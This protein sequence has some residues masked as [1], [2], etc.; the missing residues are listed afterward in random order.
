MM[1][2]IFPL[3]VLLIASVACFSQGTK[4]L[5]KQ[6]ALQLPNLGAAIR[7]WSPQ[8]P[9][10]R[11]LHCTG[12]TLDTATAGQIEITVS[13]GSS[14]TADE[15]TLHLASNVFSIKSTYDATLAKLASPPLT[16]TPTAPTPAANTNTTQIPT[17]A[18]VIAE[19]TNPSTLTNKR[20]TQRIGTTASSAT[21][22]PD[23]DNND[24][25]TVT[26]LAANATFAA[27]TGTPTDGQ[28]LLIRITSDATIRT[29]AW[30]AIYT[31]ATDFA[32]PVATVASK[33]LYI[34]FI[35]NSAATKWQAV[36][37][38]RDF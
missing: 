38:T 24:V 28:S 36:G 22:T 9:G 30:N 20:I 37:M 17:T 31:A 16:G 14:Y 10:L 2:K 26:A 7:L 18:F 35:Y 5:I 12:C 23:G 25:F 15:S 3:L 27:P 6:G 19:R 32:L 34:Q 33:T 11:S 13:A 8:S 29:L 21:P 1:K 4:V